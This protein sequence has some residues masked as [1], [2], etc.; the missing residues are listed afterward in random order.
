MYTL[1]QECVG[2]YENNTVL[3]NLFAAILWIAYGMQCVGELNK[4]F[5][6]NN[7]FFRDY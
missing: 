1:E 6:Q 7:R 4:S 3:A 2:W 5:M